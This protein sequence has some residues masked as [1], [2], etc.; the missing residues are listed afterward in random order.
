VKDEESLDCSESLKSIIASLRPTVDVLYPGLE[1]PSGDF[2]AQVQ[3]FVDSQDDLSFVAL[4]SAKSTGPDVAKAISPAP[5]M[6]PISMRGPITRKRRRDATPESAVKTRSAK[7]TTT[8]RL[9]HDN[10]QIQFAPIVSSP[11]AGESQ[12]L[13]ER[14]MEVRQRQEENAGLYSD[15]R[16][17]PRPGSRAATEE[18]PKDSAAQK[19]GNLETTP[20]RKASYEEFITSTPTPR[21]GLALHLEGINDPPSSPPEPRRNPLLSEIQTRSKARDSMESWQFSS[22][23]GSP[24]IDLQATKTQPE[25]ETPTKSNSSAKNK[26]SKRRGRKSRSSWKR[27]NAS[28]SPVDQDLTEEVS[29]LSDTHLTQNM[30]DAE[31]DKAVTPT[32]N[33]AGDPQQLRGTPKSGED[34]FVD[35]Q[36]SP[37]D[38]PDNAALTVAQKQAPNQNLESSFALSEG[39]ESSFMRFVVELE[40]RPQHD[41]EQ[42]KSVSVSP[43]NKKRGSPP[44]CIEVQG[45][46]SSEEEQVITKQPSPA[47]V[48][49]STPVDVASEISELPT[50]NPRGSERKRKRSTHSVETRSKRRRSTKLS[51]QEQVGNSQPTSQEPNSP[52]PTVRRSSRRNAGLKDKELRNQKTEASPT[53]KSKRSSVSQAPQTRSTH[54]DTRDGGDTDEELMSQLVT[55]SI[56]ASQSQEL[57]VKIPDA[58][59]E[60]S[61][62]VLEVEE[63]A[64][65][66]ELAAENREGSVEETQDAV[67]AQGET[68]EEVSSEVKPDLIMETL[69]GGLKQLQGAALSRDEVYRLEDMLMDMKRELFEAER[70]GRL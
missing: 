17:S 61:M 69:R 58:V 59:V 55:E 3:S 24:S 47:E 28:S 34:E 12:H 13:T 36:T 35:A 54:T 18:G 44:A 43:E 62:E 64:P 29:V 21:R 39:D 1:E 15:I 5:S 65:T 56:A 7:R 51:G 30:E 46:T 27:D 67:A 38:V 19:P 52:I 20:E 4:S 14:Q 22:P 70:R 37:I 57:D 41:R 40:S 68:K 6:T 42:F 10:S 23:P 8:P 2:G 63:A 53:K 32:R 66:E 45:D 11:L 9:R 26:R 49:P 48:I 50:T 16:S 25:A 31:E 60:D 33:Q